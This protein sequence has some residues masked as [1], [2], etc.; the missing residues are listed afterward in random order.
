MIELDINITGTAEVVGRLRQFSDRLADKV[1]TLAVRSGA[2]Y[3][4]DRVKANAPIRTGRLK[5]AVTTKASR[6]NTRRKNNTIGQYVTV[7]AGKKRNDHKGAYYAKFIEDGWTP[8]GHRSR[9]IP[10]RNFVKNTF[11]SSA[12]TAAQ[13]IITGIEQSGE[14]LAR[15]LGL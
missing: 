12:S 5:R 10:G 3:L 9:R 7:K 11:N 8:R 13:I 1:V 6:I 14:Q 2:N 15:R 4:R